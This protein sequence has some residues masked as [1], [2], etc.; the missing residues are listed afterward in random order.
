[1]EKL[2]IFYEELFGFL[3]YVLFFLGE[4]QLINRHVHR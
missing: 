1:M 2:G 3:A 4:Q